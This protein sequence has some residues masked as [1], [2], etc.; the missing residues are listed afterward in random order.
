MKEEHPM[1]RAL[2]A[3]AWMGLLAAAGHAAGADTWPARPVRVVVGFAAGGPDTMA[4]LIAAQLAQQTGHQFIVDN[5]PGA[6]GVIGADIVAKSTPDGQT[7]LYTSASFAVNPSIYRKLPYDVLKDFAPLS[8]TSQAGGHIV[9]VTPS[10][11]VRSVQEL[12]ALAR[13]PESRL[14]YGSPGLGN[15]THLVTALFNSRIGGHMLHVPYKG[16]G[17]SLAAL[18]AGEIQ[19]MF[20]TSTLGLPHIQAGKLRPLAYD[21]P[22]RAP[23]LPDVPTLAEAGGPPTGMNVTWHGMFAPASTPAPLRARIEAEIV[24]AL[25]QPTVRER[26]GKLGLYPIGS[27]SKQF[28]PFVADAIRRFAEMVRLAGVQ[29]E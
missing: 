7:L 15:T 20:A 14:S 9:T 3:C 17:P 5:R 28:T 4:R 1:H 26:I 25:G 6:N 10:L 11:P 21:G 22:M 8:Q 12:I 24:K 13:K 16:A 29:P 23:F 19:L 18:V 2:K 27:S